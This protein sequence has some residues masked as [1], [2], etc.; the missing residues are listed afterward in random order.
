MYYICSY[1]SLSLC[2]AE[3]MKKKHS[4]DFMGKESYLWIDVPTRSLHW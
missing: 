4:A 1:L 3:L 2:R